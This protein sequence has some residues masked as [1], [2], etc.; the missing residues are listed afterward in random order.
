M[1]RRIIV[2]I[3]AGV[4]LLAATGL[5]L[6]ERQYNFRYPCVRCDVPGH[7]WHTPTPTPPAFWIYQF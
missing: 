4:L 6:F 5:Y 7:I 1:R 3:L 2:I